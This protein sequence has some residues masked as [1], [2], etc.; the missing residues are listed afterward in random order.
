MTSI[1]QSELLEVTG[2]VD[3]HKDRHVAAAV[4]AIGRFLGTA[5][6]P[7]TPAG[8]QQLL[9][10][11]AGFGPVGR[12]GVEGTGS[13]GAGLTRYLQ[14]QGV[15]VIEV[16]RPNRQKRRRRGKSDPVDAEAAARA[17]LAGEAT[18]AP[19]SQDGLVEAIRMLRLTRRSAVKAR[20]QALNQV[21][22]LVVTA[23]E[24]LRGQLR[25]LKRDRL[26]KAAAA[27]QVTAEGID[28]P[29]AGARFA[30]RG[31]GRRWQALT[32]EIAESDRELG[33]LLGQAAPELLA[34]FGV[35]PEVAATLLVTAGDN[36]E[37]LRSDASLA[38]LCGVSP[39]EASS[40]KHT[41]HRLNRG[42]NRQANNALWRVVIVRMGR[43]EPTRTYVARRT[44]EGKTKK[45]IIRC[46]KRYVA[47]EI[48]GI[49]RH[50]TSPTPA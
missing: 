4:D 10:W 2:G 7:A 47:R 14:A 43:H 23:P 25:H 15:A 40:G 12:V 13:W 5:A 29:L 11:L 17:V 9:A 35:G 3:S 34:V 20:T 30:L 41:R 6:F 16:D 28:G 49:L 33:V 48:Y 31:L 37:R 44:A 38:A 36:R 18:G 45:E 1:A 39:V 24:P 50:I 32:A 27:L 46:L 8:Y 21:H 19:K 26:G 42:G 22:A